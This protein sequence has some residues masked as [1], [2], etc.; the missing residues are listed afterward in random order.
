MLA[1]SV[2]VE[3]EYY[4]VFPKSEKVGSVIEILEKCLS[5]SLVVRV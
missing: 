5:N 4:I 1:P 2:Y 3:V